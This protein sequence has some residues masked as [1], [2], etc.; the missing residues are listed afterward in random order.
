MRDLI[1]AVDW[2]IITVNKIVMSETTVVKVVFFIFWMKGE[3]LNNDLSET[4]FFYCSVLIYV[5]WRIVE[6]KQCTLLMIYEFY[7]LKRRRLM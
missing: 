2:G 1:S 7:F 4:V 6:G 5:C 3:T